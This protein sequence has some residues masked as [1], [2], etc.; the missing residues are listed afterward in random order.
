M[1]GPEP[2]SDSP[3][4][5]TLPAPDPSHAALPSLDGAELATARRYA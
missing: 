5:A 3:V 2:P 4:P 1:R